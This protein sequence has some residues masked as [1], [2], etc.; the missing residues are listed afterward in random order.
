MKPSHGGSS[1]GSQG[2]NDRSVTWPQMPP[3][4]VLVP[5]PRESRARLRST[6]PPAGRPTTPDSARKARVDKDQ[7]KELQRNGAMTI[8]FH[9]GPKSSAPQPP[10]AFLDRM[11]KHKELQEKKAERIKDMQT[12]TAP[13]APERREIA[14]AGRGLMQARFCGIQSPATRSFCE[15]DRCNCDQSATRSVGSSRGYE[16]LEIIGR[17]SFGCAILARDPRGRRKVLKVI[18]LECASERRKREAPKE[19]EIMEKLKH[20][21]IVRIHETFAEDTALIIV[22]EYA[23]SGD[24]RQQVKDARRRECSFR[25]PKILRGLLVWRPQWMGVTISHPLEAMPPSLRHPP[26]RPARPIDS[27]DL[28]EEEGLERSAMFQGDEFDKLGFAASPEGDAVADSAKSYAEWFQAKAVRRLRRLESRRE[29]LP[30]SGDWSSLPKNTLKALLRKGVPHEHRPELWWSILGCEAERLRSPVSF[31][32]YLEEPVD[33]ATAET[34]ERDLPRTFPNHQKFRCAAGRAE[35]RNVL[36]AFSRRCPA[37][38]YCQGMNFIAAL[39]LIV[40]QDEERAF[41]MFVC[42]FDALGVEGYYTEGMTLL[43]ADMQVLA[44]CMQAKCAKVSRTLNQFNVDLLSISSEWYITWFAKS[45]PVPTVLRVWDTLFFEGFKVLFRVSIGIFKQI[46][47]D[48][49]KSDGFDAIMQQ[50]KRW[51]RSL[52]EHNELMKASFQGLPSFPRH[53]LQKA[54]EEALGRIEKEDLERKRAAKARLK[55]VQETVR[56]EFMCSPFWGWITQALVGLRHIHSMNILHRDLKSENLFLENE[57]RLRIGDFGIA[58]AV[59]PPNKAVLESNVV[60]TP[61]YMSPETCSMGLHSFAGDVWAMGCVLYELSAL[62]LPYHGDTLD[63]LMAEITRKA[64]PRFPI[65]YS[66]ELAKVYAAVL[67]HNRNK[68]PSASDV[69]FMQPLH[70]T[71]ESLLE[72]SEKAKLSRPSSAPPRKKAPEAD[73]A[74]PSLEKAPDEG[75]PAQLPGTAAPF[76][77]LQELRR[78]AD[79]PLPVLCAAAPPEAPLPPLRP[80]SA[81]L[82]F[83]WFFLYAATMRTAQTQ[84]RTPRIAGDCQ[85]LLSRRPTTSAYAGAE[86]LNPE[87]SAQVTQGSR[88]PATNTLLNRRLVVVKASAL[89]AAKSLSQAVA[90]GA[91]QALRRGTQQPKKVP[92]SMLTGIVQEVYSE[93]ATASRSQVR[94][95]AMVRSESEPPIEIC[96]E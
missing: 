39:L 41:W 60:G 35:L 71:L 94:S 83:L 69:L 79:A 16:A 96:A 36:R 54:R 12:K 48:V 47:Q 9:D 3:I 21:Y 78:N 2:D 37:V 31:Q 20:P 5:Q 65:T 43:R 38:R 14:K 72:E 29:K 18:D 27:E 86:D 22:M 76:R 51:P 28:S 50:A 91:R 64:A 45:L 57:D 10:K 85:R 66:A 4:E 58:C 17:G 6:T 63:E 34:I 90:R 49:L 26:P 75:S 68:R 42:A 61:Y 1:R 88:G 77:R 11:E 62:K 67:S 52:V 59:K 44:S 84:V 15:M 82:I 81:D 55:E 53:Q 93:S 23:G 24:L 19:A 8:P 56:K 46:E 32:Q 30:A 74:Y 89:D 92:D 33:S 95:R 80:S 7:K 73:T 25:E 70:Q 13:A 40:S 87:A